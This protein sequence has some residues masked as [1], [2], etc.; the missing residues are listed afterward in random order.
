M[1]LDGENAGRPKSP[2]ARG[3]E[4]PYPAQ[5]LIA[6]PARDARTLSKAVS[7][8]EATVR[9]A[10]WM[11]NR[12][13]TALLRT[14]CGCIGIPLVVS[15]T[16][17]AFR[18]AAGELLPLDVALVDCSYG[19]ATDL[20]RCTS[21]LA[22]SACAVYCIHPRFEALDPIVKAHPRQLYT[23]P[24]SYVGVELLERLR[25]LEA[26]ATERTREASGV[27]SARTL[28]A[29]LSRRELQVCTMVAKGCSNAQIA[30]G[31]GVAASTVKTH[32]AS[33]L[34]KAGLARRQQLV[35]ALAHLVEPCDQF[36]DIPRIG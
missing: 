33:I 2:S 26:V 27:S 12:D 19:R 23:M 17:E 25:A 28:V 18:L 6:R 24:T 13:I 7:T 22:W 9:G 11:Q 31:L 3:S 14:I 4:P 30:G 5:H 15:T 16:G 34:Q 10:L 29:T 20:S 8:G 35:A 21:A 1:I 36:P 32:V